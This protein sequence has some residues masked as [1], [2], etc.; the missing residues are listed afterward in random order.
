MS[1]VGQCL[2]AAGLGD[3]CVQ[4]HGDAYALSLTGAAVDLTDFDASSGE[5][6]GPRRPGT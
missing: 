1:S 2:A 5:R 3:D 4:R 6:H